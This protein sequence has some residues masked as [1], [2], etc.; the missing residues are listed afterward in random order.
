MRWFQLLLCALSSLD[1]DAMASMVDI[2][3][4]SFHLV[5]R[6]WNLGERLEGL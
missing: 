6:T 3:S 1:V 2:A 5:L 4:M